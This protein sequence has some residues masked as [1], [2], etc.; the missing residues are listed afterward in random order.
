MHC[1]VCALNCILRDKALYHVAWSCGKFVSWIVL[2]YCYASYWTVSSRIMY[3]NVSF[4]EPFSLSSFSLMWMLVLSVWV[5]RVECPSSCFV[6]L[7]SP[8]LFHLE[9]PCFWWP[10]VSSLMALKWS[11]LRQGRWTQWAWVHGAGL[12]ARRGRKNS[13]ESFFPGPSY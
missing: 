4:T 6:L 8:V 12:C 3:C 9:L 2:M 13:S 5:N 10:S 7:I 1:V 11:W